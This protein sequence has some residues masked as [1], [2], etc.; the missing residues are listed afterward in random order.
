MVKGKEPSHHTFHTTWYG[1]GKK[2]YFIWRLRHFIPL[3]SLSISFEFLV[4]MPSH[5][6]RVSHNLLINK[7]YFFFSFFLV[8]IRL[9]C[10]LGLRE[11]INQ[12][13]ACYKTSSTKNSSKIS[14]M[15]LMLLI[16]LEA[17]FSHALILQMHS[18]Q[19]WNSSR[20]KAEESNAN[21]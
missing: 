6:M 19:P 3:T 8:Y 7:Y 1:W 18:L 2:Y 16:Y 14:I 4:H 11:K 13:V 15:S 9:R 12:K 10:Y 17:I 5:F 20:S 21:I